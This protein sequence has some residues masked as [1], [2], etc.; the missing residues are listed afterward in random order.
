MVA[1]SCN[2]SLVTDLILQRDP[3]EEFKKAF[4]LFD[5]DG[6]GSI[7]LRNLR[8]VARLVS[9]I[10]SKLRKFRIFNEQGIARNNE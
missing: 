5:D 7:S 9:F 2:F 6:T 4:Q 1:N 3:Q 8:R 10:S